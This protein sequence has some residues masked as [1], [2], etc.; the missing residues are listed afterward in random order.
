MDGDGWDYQNFIDIGIIIM[1]LK[2]ILY[3]QSKIFKIAS[4]NVLAW[5]LKTLTVS[6]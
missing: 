6:C 3:H 5:L 1:Y 2:S 4:L